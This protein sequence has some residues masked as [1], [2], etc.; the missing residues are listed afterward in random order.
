MVT[1]MGSKGI[2]INVF[3]LIQIFI[4]DYLFPPVSLLMSVANVDSRVNFQLAKPIAAIENT[5]R[6]KASTCSGKSV[7]FCL[8]VIEC[9]IIST[10]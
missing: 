1:Y 4:V 6:T 8:S 10:P 5:T 9:L 2:S 3:A 7:F